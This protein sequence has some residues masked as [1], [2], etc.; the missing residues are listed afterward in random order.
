MVPHKGSVSRDLEVRM[1]E[2][3]GLEHQAMKSS[4]ANPHSRSGM[5]ASTTFGA[6]TST[7]EQNYVDQCCG[8]VTFWYGSGS[9]PLTCGSGSCFFSSVAFK[10]P[11]KNKFLFFCSLPYFLKVH[12]HQS[13][14]IKSQK[15]DSRNQGFS[16]FL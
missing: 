3:L 8:S 7:T 11:T 16:S 14:K 2:C 4:L 10:M 6:G 9:A 12:L 15:E 1:M 13:S 5:L